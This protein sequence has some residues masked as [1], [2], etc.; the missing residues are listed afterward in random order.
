MQYQ[1]PEIVRNINIFKLFPGNSRNSNKK[2]IK[3]VFCV[4]KGRKQQKDQRDRGEKEKQRVKEPVRI[5]LQISITKK[6]SMHRIVQSNQLFIRYNY[7]WLVI[8][9]LQ[10]S[11]HSTQIISNEH[12]LRA[13][14]NS[15]RRK[16]VHTCILNMTVHSYV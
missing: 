9:I 10:N 6:Y 13:C 5:F 2:N 16:Q 3:N 11:I 8:A 7:N 4:N 15:N 12:I 1:S 14:P